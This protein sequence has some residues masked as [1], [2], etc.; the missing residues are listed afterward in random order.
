MIVAWVSSHV[1]RVPACT[2][3]QVCLLYA[4][5]LSKALHDDRVRA[6][7]GDAVTAAPQPALALV[8]P[9]PLHNQPLPGVAA[10]RVVFA[11]SDWR[12]NG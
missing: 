3:P 12:A 10:N 4:L 1:S 8:R 9:P 5:C 6:A 7:L 2:V 11:T